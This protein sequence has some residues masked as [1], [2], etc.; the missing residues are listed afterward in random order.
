MKINLNEK[1]NI[2]YVDDIETNLILF[3]S[4][5]Q[6]DFNV[7]VADS[8]DKAIELLKKEHFA[9][10]ISDQRMPGMSGTELLEIV[11]QEYP[12][13]IRFMLTAYSDY[14]TVVD[15]INKGQIYGFFNKPFDAG[16]VRIS[17]HKAVEVHNLRVSNRK[18]I[19]EIEKANLELRNI[20]KSKTAFL[21]VITN[22][23]R[24]PINK[25]LSVVHMLKDTVVSSD[26]AELVNYLDISVSRIEKFSLITNQL[27][28][29]TEGKVSVKMD[30]VSIRELVEISILEKKELLD[31][32][33]IKIQMGVH[34]ENMK[35][36]GDYE[37]LLN[38]L[39][40]ILDNSLHFAEKG[41]ELGISSGENNTSR[42]FEINSIGN[43]SEKMMGNLI[44]HF[45]GEEFSSDYNVGIDLI[46]AKQIMSLHKGRIELIRKEEKSISFLLI[47]PLEVIK[48]DDVKV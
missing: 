37:L 34:S 47:F 23:L 12:D 21:N 14:Q 6:N 27:A 3:E 42:F 41:S 5:F 39:T 43:Y 19:V 4:A 45:S 1:A 26:L 38:C 25:I 18:M 24:S 48:H 29:L 10:I 33:G 16:E 17:L 9:V 15:S 8:G 13:I 28:K 46:L 7:F 44:R 30:D 40:I 35:I 22:E 20:D 32:M 2:I 31:A 11:R 36:K